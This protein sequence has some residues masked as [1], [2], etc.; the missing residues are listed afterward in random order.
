VSTFNFKILVCLV[1]LLFISACSNKAKLNVPENASQH[2]VSTDLTPEGLVRM[3]Q[4]MEAA[5][6]YNGAGGFYADALGKDRKLIQAHLGL[7]RV[8]EAMGQDSLAIVS[9][10][11]AFDLDQNNQEALR[12]Y[13]RGLLANDGEN[14]ALDALNKHLQTNQPTPELLNFKGISLDLFGDF[15]AAEN[16]FRQGLNLTQPGDVWNGRL[17][18]NLAL[19]LGLAGDTS[20]A[21]LILNPYI[22]DM[23]MGR[24][25]LTPYQS[26]LRQNLA[27][28]YALSGN[29]D[30]AVEVAKSA[31]SEQDAEYNRGFY[32]AVATLA[33]RDRVR[34]VLLGKL[35]EG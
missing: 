25:G 8:L 32:Q 5:G 11:N 23:R 31:L 14:L 22:G 10:G 20:E 29:P 24:E 30:S 26:Q 9:Y 16:A 17:L 3:G 28:I 33:G 7:G 6:D 4:R 35:P 27:L 21:I 2:P 18:G 12:G 13:V 1:A 19:S 34:A 15:G